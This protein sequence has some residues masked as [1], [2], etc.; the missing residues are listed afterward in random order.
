MTINIDPNIFTIGFVTLS[1]HGLFSALGVLLGVLFAARLLRDTS[2]TDD[3]YYSAALWG[4]IGG[5]VGARLL[6][7]IENIY[8]FLPSP[9]SVFAINEGG[10]SV[11]GATLGGTLAAYFGA[12][13]YGIHVPTVADAAG[14]GFSLGQGIGRIG[15]IINGEHHGAPTDLPWG[16][17]YTH[18][19]TLGELDVKV[20]PA[21]GYEM[22]YNFAVVGLLLLLRGR[23][24][25]P[26]M[27]YLLYIFLYSLGRLTVGFFRK[28]NLVLFNLGMA[29][30]IGVAGM[31]VCA[32][33]ALVMVTSNT[34]STPPRSQRRRAARHRT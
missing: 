29:Q 15:D 32:I 19:N 26:G 24:P 16:I 17:V 23:L 22:I 13:R 7:V 5:I 21:V 3:Q 12:K 30:L 28:D 33:W 27:I 31:I 8:L 11:F 6:F 9:L 20:H 18:P 34:P 4:I 2:I 10:I 1:W 14:P 25:R